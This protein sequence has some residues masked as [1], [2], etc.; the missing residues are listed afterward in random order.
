MD[1]LKIVRDLATADRLLMSG[2]PVT[3]SEVY[4]IDG[5]S[6][7]INA[8]GRIENEITTLDAKAVTIP[9]SHAPLSENP[10]VIEIVITALLDVAAGLPVV[11][12]Y[13]WEIGDQYAN[14][15]LR[16]SVVK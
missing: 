6:I 16:V 13:T 5:K 2:N 9:A 3:I 15:N 11:E 1:V 8:I 12:N 14:L 10:S 7:S 4:A